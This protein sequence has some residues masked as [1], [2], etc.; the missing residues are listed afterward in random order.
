MKK[1]V[2]LFSL[3]AL[4]VLTACAAEKPAQLHYQCDNGKSVMTHVMND[5]KIAVQ[6]DGGDIHVLERVVAPSGKRYQG[7][8]FGW[9][10]K[11]AS[12]GTLTLQGGAAIN[13]DASA[14]AVR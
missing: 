5:S 10:D 12:E 7:Q 8:G 9:W 1:F 6:Y 3:C 14:A 2:P 13:C 11:T 4:A